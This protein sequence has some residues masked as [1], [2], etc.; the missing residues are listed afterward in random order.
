MSRSAPTAGP[1][2]GLFASL[3]SPPPAVAGDYIPSRG[4]ALVDARRRLRWLARRAATDEIGPWELRG[5]IDLVLVAAPDIEDGNPAFAALVDLHDRLIDG[6]P[7][8]AERFIAAVGLLGS[9]V[10]EA[11]R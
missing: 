11:L 3:S 9:S 10:Q 6:K 1:L 4:E 2:A 7:V 8:L 5:V